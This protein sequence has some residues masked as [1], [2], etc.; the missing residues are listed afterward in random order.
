MELTTLS[1]SGNTSTPA[2]Y[3]LGDCRVADF[4]TI[5]EQP[6]DLGDF[7]L[8]DRIDQGVVVYD[9]RSLRSRISEA[10]GRLEVQAELVR[11]LS[12]GPGVL[13]LSGAFG[14][15]GVLDA[16]T[17]VFRGIIEAEKAAGTAAGDH[18]ATPGANDRVWNALE[19]FAVADP[20]AFLRYY[21]NDMLA[22]ICEA[23]LGPRYQVTSQL[24]QVNPGGKAQSPHRDY[25]LGFQTMQ[26]AQAFPRHIHQM[27]AMLTLQGA[28]AHVDMPME[29]GPTF[30]IPNSQKY[31]PGY[32]ASHLPEFQKYSNERAVQVPLGRGDAI[33]F[34]P[35]LFHGAGENV[36][37]DVRRLGNLLQISSAFGRAMESI[38]RARMIRAIY[39]SLVKWKA[40]GASEADLQNVIAA[41]AEGYAFPGDL[42]SHPPSGSEP[43]PAQADLVAIA[44]SEEWPP[45]RLATE[46]ASLCTRQPVV[47][48][49]RSS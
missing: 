37:D 36:S 17:D 12:E 11:V 10:P 39:P 40:S 5:V 19:K 2:Y 20:D 46:V 1:K 6:V 45:S 23:W 15:D 24:N 48:D 47:T 35:A 42:D 41:S 4:A 49:I 30:L 14:D 33:F 8:A 31:G 9:S 22:L 18:F 29:T 38:D 7:P 44:L 25:H 3:S 16:A 13:V 21:A 43:P 27:S 34:N 26:S 28:V 32:I